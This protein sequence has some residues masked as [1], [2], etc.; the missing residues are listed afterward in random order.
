MQIAK[1]LRELEPARSFIY[2]FIYFLKFYFY[3]DFFFPLKDT[4]LYRS[5]T[6]SPFASS[7]YSIIAHGKLS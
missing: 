4:V 7:I 5:E 6:D 1:I 2:L 3:I